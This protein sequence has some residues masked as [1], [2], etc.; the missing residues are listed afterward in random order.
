MNKNSGQIENHNFYNQ[1]L[2]EPTKMTDRSHRHKHWL[3]EHDRLSNLFRND[4]LSFERER[5][6]LIRAV[7]NNSR[8]EM[9]RHRLTKL[10]KRWDHMLKH[11]CSEH[12]RFILI[13]ML[14][15]EQVNNQ[16]LPA[17]KGYRKD[18]AEW[19]SRL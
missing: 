14:F 6:A 15:W 10:Q 9:G 18:L 4:R 3:D 19:H 16:W 13:Q 1:N 2:V 12:N 17:L 7:I 11:A 8:T 5:R